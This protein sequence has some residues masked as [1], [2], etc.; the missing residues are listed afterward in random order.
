MNRTAHRTPLTA[1]ALLGALAALAPL[2]SSAQETTKPKLTPPGE[3]EA[4]IDAARPL[5]GGTIPQDLKNIL[6]TTHYDGHYSRTDKPF[7]IEG[8]AEIE[9]LGMNVAKF[10]LHEDGLPGYGYHS[11]WGIPL[12][13]DLVGILKHPYYKEALSHP[14]TTVIFEVFPLSGDKKS[15]FSGDN[16]FADEEKEFYRVA[17]YLLKTY[18]DRD[19]NFILQNWEGDWMLRREEGGTWGNVPP[20]EVQRRCDAFVKFLAARQRGVERARKEAGK[21]KAKVYNAAEVNRVWDGLDGIATLTTKVLPNVT[22]DLVSWS[23]YDGLK[24]PVHLWQGVEIIRQSMRPSPTFGNNAVYIGEIGRE[25]NGRTEREIVEFWDKCMGVLLA[26]KVP[27]IVQWELYCNEPKDSSTKQ[28][29]HP[30]QADEMVG[31]WL[32]RPDGSLGYAGKYLTAL[33][34]N[35][36]GKLP[37]STVNSLLPRT[38]ETAVTPKKKDGNRHEAFLERIKQGD[39]DVL[40]VG[41]SIT[42][43]WSKRGERSWLKFADLKPADFGVSG[44]C[45][46]HVLWRLQNGELDGIRPKLVV[47]LIG[48]NN[49]RPEVSEEPEWCAAG[50]RK[51]LDEIRAKLP[52]TKILLLAIFPRDTPGDVTRERIDKVNGIIA[53]YADGKTIRFLDIGKI[54][55]DEQG[56]I[57]VG[58]MGDKLHPNAFGYDKWYDAMRPEIDSMLSSSGT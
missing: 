43:G 27:F 7:L 5:L 45:T 10:W 22:V 25:E 2:R 53:S 39:I 19:I 21:T 55:L 50:I 38:A 44:D 47:L 40:F 9:R 26:M 32:I 31:F 35:A 52:E 28:D 34:K 16:D 13:H 14:F 41:D 56:N 8:A 29:R 24:D 3:I 4:K 11:D 20:E 42:D 18:A 15:F 17:S 36:G 51:I 23:C 48:T 6:G 30:R 33:L 54:F 1:L 46:E 57:P 58:L 49:L 12:D 37:V